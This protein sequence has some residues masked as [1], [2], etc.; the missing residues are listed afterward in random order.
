MNEIYSQAFTSHMNG[1][2][3]N[4]PLKYESQV[5]N[6]KSIPVPADTSGGPASTTGALLGQVRWAIFSNQY[7]N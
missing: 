2:P 3:T 7:V 1:S 6:A 4:N 5:V